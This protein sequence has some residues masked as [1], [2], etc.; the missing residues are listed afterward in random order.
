MRPGPLGTQPAISNHGL[1]TTVYKPSAKVSVGSSRS[2]RAVH[3]PQQDA[4]AS[5][6]GPDS[7][8]TSGRRTS[9]PLHAHKLKTNF[10]LGT[11]KEGVG[12]LGVTL[13]VVF[14]LSLRGAELPEKWGKITKF[15]S[16][17]GPSK[18]G[19]KHKKNYKIAVSEYFYPFW[20]QFFLLSGVRETVIFH[21]F[22]GISAPEAFRALQ[23]QKQLAKVTT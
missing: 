14:S 10:G 3:D 18:L 2:T 19:K 13:S 8:C 16:P 21:H 17:G 15:L 4:L 6:H 1:E 7:Q 5:C 12:K 20:G 9:G 22:S 23:G 11:F